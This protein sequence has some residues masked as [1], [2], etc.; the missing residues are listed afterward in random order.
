MI[1]LTLDE[2]VR[3]MQGRR[4]CVVA[5]TRITGVSTDSRT[6]SAGDL[7]FA[8]AGPNHDGAKF[9][10]GA[11]ERGAAAAVVS[12]EAV[13]DDRSLVYVPD[14]VEALGRLAAFHRTQRSSHVIAVTGSNGKTTTKCMIDHVLG[15]RFKG[16]S[17]PKSFNNN[18]GV[19]VTLLSSEV[20]D[21]FL[22]VEIG[23][24]APGEIASLGAL[25]S[26]T[27]VV[28]TSIGD[29]HLAGFGDRAGVTR[30]KLSLLDCLRKG[31][32]AIV[33]MD[34]FDAAEM[35]SIRARA[36]E[37]TLVT[38]G[39][40][41]QA[42]V[43]I[44]DVETDLDGTRFVLNGRERVSLPCIGRHNAL[45]AAAAFAVG[46][47]LKIEPDVIVAALATFAPP[48]MRLNVSRAGNVTVIDDS[49]NANPT[50]TSAAI[51]VLRNVPG[52]RRV[53]VGGGM[54][55]LGAKSASLHE[56]AGRMLAEAG[57]GLLV[58]IGQNGAD[59]IAGAHTVSR[60][61]T[62]VLYADTET[63][64]CDLPNWLT[65]AD[66]VLIKG[67]RMLSLDRVA[68]AVRKSFA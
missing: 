8:L 52:G 48:P 4:S 29:A 34:D 2:I 44:T 58:A 23:A 6:C 47:R 43:R 61:M 7:F 45:N 37:W 36:G 64:C 1:A 3:V 15:T 31:G 18:I 11:F 51:D 59:L 53:F 25:A 9:L 20:G 16:R 28:I 46:R 26:P 62:T 30:E 10:N 12:G 41:E 50:S 13:A 33:N 65:D 38:F 14:T 60:T 49:Y 27:V 19:P 54:L 39:V 42:D 21:E 66:T 32:L 56:Q 68:D 57:V 24:N 35:A 40:S 63:A 17:A 55:E 22:V 67:S 5:H